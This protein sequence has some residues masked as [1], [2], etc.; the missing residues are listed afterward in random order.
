MEIV[1]VDDCIT[2]VYLENNTNVYI[3]DITNLRDECSHDNYINNPILVEL[4]P[5]EID[6]KILVELHDVGGGGG[7]EDGNQAAISIT[8][9]LNEFIIKPESQKFWS[10]QGCSASYKYSTKR[11]VYD[12]YRIAYSLLTNDLKNFTFVFQISS[13]FDVI[14][15]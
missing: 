14:D 4:L 1:E 13:L 9:Y 11:N 5:Y 8:V 2:R 10:C 12:Y 7:E 3:N 15:F 6:Q